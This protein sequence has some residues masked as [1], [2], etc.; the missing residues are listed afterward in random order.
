MANVVTM[1]S[2]RMMATATAAATSETTTTTTTTTK[3]RKSGVKRLAKHLQYMVPEVRLALIREPER[4]ALPVQCP[5]DVEKFVEPLKFYDAEHF[6]AFHLNARHEVTGY[7][8]V[9]KGTVSASLVHPREVFKAAIL[10]NSYA[11]LVAHNHPGG[12]MSPSREDLETTEQL[13]KA[14]KLLGIS[15]VD[16][17]IVSVSGVYSIRE[18]YPEYWS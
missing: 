5:E 7:F 12:S 4:K 2:G 16:H 13:I 8:I 15:V 11:I 18:N 3:A 6:V 17:V 9:S 14:G 1:A 10:A